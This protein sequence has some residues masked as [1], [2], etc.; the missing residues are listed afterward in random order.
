MAGKSGGFR[1]AFIR[2]LLIAVAAYVAVCG[3]A[4]WQKEAIIFPVR[5][6]GRAVGKTAPAGFETWWQTMR[7]GTRV[8]A[9]WRPIRGATPERPAPAVLV[10]HGNGEL[11]DDSRE[12]AEVWNAA[13]ASVL[14]VEY[15]GYGRSGGAPGVASCTGDA[16]EW[17]DRVAATPGVRSDAVLAYGF[18]LGGVFA[19]ELAALRPVAGLAMEGSPAGLVEIARDRGIWLVFS[20]ERFDGVAA[21]AKPAPEVPVLLTHGRPDAVIPFRHLDLLA[22]ARPHA[23][24]VAGDHPHEPFA[25]WSRPVL[26]RDLLAAAVARADKTLASAGPAS[27]R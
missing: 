8:E 18:S 16:V 1:R 10:F 17:F 4:A 24:V 14:L 9:W 13:G 25:A 11:I 5:G 21:L 19:A 6:H 26:L 15:R 20:R 2:W 12:L 3:V 7:D 23:T 22:R 27:A